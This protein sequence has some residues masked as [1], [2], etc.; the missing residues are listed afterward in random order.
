[1]LH[2][3]VQGRTDKLLALEEIVEELLEEEGGTKTI[4][5]VF[6]ERRVT[7]MALHTYFLWRSER[8]SASGNW[9]YAK[10]IRQR[11]AHSE[12][13]RRKTSMD[14]SEGQIFDDSEDDPFHFSLKP[15]D[16]H[17][18]AMDSR[19]THST[20]REIPEQND[21]QVINVHD[22]CVYETNGVGTRLPTIV[23]WC[24]KFPRIG[25]N[26][27]QLPMFSRTSSFFRREEHREVFCT[28]EKPSSNLQLV[29]YFSKELRRIDTKAATRHM[30]SSRS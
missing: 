10:Q 25:S 12:L 2:R 16:A 7:A 24:G 11:T 1:V 3:T 29:E 22:D 17:Q 18:S 19:N 9:S 15:I 28:R 14:G 30:D 4:G 27:M 26:I 13:F 21:Q 8:I 5:L 6:V 23:D 20:I